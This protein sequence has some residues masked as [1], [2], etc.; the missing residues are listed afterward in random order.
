MKKLIMTLGIFLSMPMFAADTPVTLETLR[1]Q[2]TTLTS[3]VDAMKK[4]L[5]SLRLGSAVRDI[6]TVKNT[7]SNQGVQVVRIDMNRTLL[8]SDKSTWTTTWNPVATYSD[9]GGNIPGVVVHASNGVTLPAG[10]Y[11]FRPEVTQGGSINSPPDPYP[12]NS[13]Y[14]GSWYG[15]GTRAASE[16]GRYWWRW[17]GEGG[18][19]TG[20]VGGDVAWPMNL[21]AV[22]TF[23]SATT[24]KVHEPNYE[25]TNKP[26]IYN[27]AIAGTYPYPEQFSATIERL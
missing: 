10:T 18:H 23:A 6:G 13:R 11:Q 12:R 7:V 15:G 16:L 4:L 20:R 8:S 21:P 26:A 24:I 22:F 5:D 2:I 19:A 27:S 17:A 14:G 3:T 1:G 25:I 9:H